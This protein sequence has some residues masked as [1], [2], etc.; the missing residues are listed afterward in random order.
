MVGIARYAIETATSRDEGA[1]KS[2]LGSALGAELRRNREALVGRWLERIADRVELAP[3]RIFPTDDLLDHVPVLIDGIADYLENPSQEISADDA[4]V[5]KAME[6]GGMRHAQGFDLYQILK[7]YEILGG[8]I[9]HFLEERIDGLAEGAGPRELLECAHRL[10]RAVAV[11][12]Q[13]T[14]TQYVARQQERV[15]ERE[16]RLRGFNSA[17]SH[18]IRNRIGTIGSAIEMLDEDFVIQ[19]LALRARFRGMA[20]ENT[21]VLVRVI[22]NLIELS[23]TEADSRQQRRIMLPEAATEVVRQL[24]HFA[25]ARRVNV[26]IGDLPRVEV[27]ASQLELALSNYVSNAIKYHDPARDERWVE[28]RGETVEGYV[29]IIVADNGVGVPEDVRD[30]LFH[31][32]FRAEETAKTVE[33]TG[34]GLSILREA[35]ET[36]GGRA[37]ADFSTAGETRFAIAIPCRRGGEGVDA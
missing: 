37:W 2:L 13:A 32:F 23:R 19:D 8:I 36:L 27:A 9:H 34:L 7:E 11:I 1:M 35:I 14:A 31:R 3:V 16:Q 33:G 30:Q 5:A 28:I 12:Q 20:R 18:E 25:A 21:A 22:D 10:F 6:L 17:L 24:R 26:R 29:N 4:V 15:N